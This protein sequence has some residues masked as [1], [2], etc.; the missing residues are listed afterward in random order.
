MKIMRLVGGGGV[1]STCWPDMG[2]QVDGLTWRYLAMQI[3]NAVGGGLKCME[4][5][6]NAY[7]EDFGGGAP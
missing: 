5:S 4:I 1:F 7:T 2:S 6:S 3:L